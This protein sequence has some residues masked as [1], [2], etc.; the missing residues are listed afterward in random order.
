MQMNK[1]W[2]SICWAVSTIA[3]ITVNIKIVISVKQT[4]AKGKWYISIYGTGLAHTWALC[5]GVLI[6]KFW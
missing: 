2:L 4:K 6:L 1:I 3:E 5:Q